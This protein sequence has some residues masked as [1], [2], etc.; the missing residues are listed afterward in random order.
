[1][2]TTDPRVDAYIEKARDFTRPILIHIRSLVHGA[3]P[4]VTETMKWIF[5]HFYPNVRM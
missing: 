1:M 2:P 4:D 5:P 3:C